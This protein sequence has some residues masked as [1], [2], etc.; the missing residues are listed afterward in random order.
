MSDD[1]TKPPGP[2]LTSGPSLVTEPKTAT[3]SFSAG[4][5]PGRNA[6]GMRSAPGQDKNPFAQAFRSPW[7][8]PSGEQG[9]QQ[10]PTASFAPSITLPTGGGALRSIGE[11]FSPNPFTGTGSMSV[12]VA[13]SPGRA[14]FGPSLALNY[15]SG[16][17][18][19]PFGLG[20]QLGVP[21]ISR[22]TE[23]GVPQYNDGHPDPKQRDTFVLAGAEDLVAALDPMTGGIW[24]EERGGYRIH[25]FRPRVESSFTKIERWTELST[26]EIHWRTISASNVTSYFGKTSDARI[27]DPQ[28]SSRVFSWLLEEV[29]DDRGQ[30]MVYEYKRDDLQGVDVNAPFERTRLEG[31][32]LA[33]QRYLSRIKYGNATPNVASDWLFE[34]V[35]DYG[36]FGTWQVTG[37][38]DQLEISTTP[39]REWPQREDVFST[40]RA[41]FEL[42]TRRL[43]R[44]V[45]MFHHIAELSEEP[46][47]VAS[48]D[49][50]HDEDP[51]MTRVVGIR[52]RSYRLDELT[53]YFEYAELP[54]LDLE[55]SDSG[56]DATIHELGDPTTLANLPGGIDGQRARLVDLDGEGVPGIVLEQPEAGTFFYKPGLGDGRFGPMMA[57]RARPTLLGSSGAQLMDIDGDGQKE[58]VTFA[59]P[60]PGFF[61]RLCGHDD[62]RWGNFRSFAAVPNIDWQDPNLQLIDLVGDGFPDLLLPHANGFAWYRSRGAEGF[63]APRVVMHPGDDRSRPVLLFSDRQS[64]VQFAD[65]TG[66][67]L[68]DLVRIRNGEIAYWPNLGHGRFGP[69]VRMGDVPAFAAPDLFSPDRLR[70][71]DVDGSGTTD[72]LYLDDRGATL[73]HNRAGNRLSGGVSLNTFPGVRSVD[74]CSVVD[75]KGDGTGCLVW[76]SSLPSGRGAMIRYLALTGGQ[77]PHLLIGSRN[78]MGAETKIRY[79]P[80][81]MFY[82]RDKAAG[83]PWATRLPFPVHVV[84]RVESVDH[85]T[86]QRYV[87]TTSYH[88]GF[89]DGIEREF[90]GFGRVETWDTESFDEFGS[91][92]ALFEV[93]LFESVEADLHQPPVHTKSWF[94]TGAYF[95]CESLAEQFAKEYWQAD[96]DAFTLPPSVM[97]AGLTGAESREAARALAGTPLR[98]EV[99]ALDGSADEGRPYS[100][101]DSNAEVVR[102]QA[103]GPNPFG[104]YRVQGRESLAHYYDR[105]TDLSGDYDPRVSHELTLE[106][107]DH[108]A[109]LRTA[110]I[111]YPRRT[112][113][114][115]AKDKLYITLSESDVVHLDATDDVLR[116]A[117][118]IESRG[119]EL[120]GLTAPGSGAFAWQTILDACDEADPIDFEG[121][122]TGPGTEE[123]RLLSRSRIRYLEDDLT[124]PLA[125]GSVQSKALVY[126]SDT[127]AMTEAQRQAVYGLLTGAPTNTELQNEGGYVLDDSAW[128]IRTGH[129]T[130]DASKFYQVTS[131]DDPFGETYSVTYDSH[132]LLITAT[133]D[134]LSQTS[135]AAFDYRVLAP[136]E[137]TDPNGNR[138]QVE[139]DVLGFVV[140]SA[141]L[142]KVGDSD[143]DTLSDP[144]STF[145]Y[146]LFEWSTNGKPNW[147]KSRVRETHRDVG[148]RWLESYSYFG[149]GGGVVMTKVQARPGLA[150]ERDVNGELVFVDDV[151][152]Y[153]DTSPDVRWVGNGRVVKDNKGNVIKAYE[154]YYSSTHAYEDE[155]ELVEQGVTPLMHYDPL[156][157]LIRTDLPNGTFSKVEFTP[158]EQ[159]SYDP[160]D[161][162][163]DSDWYAA[164]YSYGGADVGLLA[165]KRAALLAADHHGTPSVVH[166]DTLGRPFLSVA[167]NIDLNDDAEYF[168]TESVLDIQG[169]VLEVVDARDNTA[170][171]RTYGMLGQSLVVSSVD[172]GDRHTLLNALGQPMR[173]WDSRSQ[174]FSYSYDTLRRPVDR[175]VSVSGGSE[176]LLGRIVYGDLLSSPEDTNH[177]GRVYRVY[178]GAGVATTVEF[179]FKGNPLE[180]QRQLVTSKTTQPD[181]SALLGQSTIAAMATAATSLL[182]SETFSASS[183]RDAVNRVLT[184]ISPDDSEV[185]YTYDEGG[186]LQAVEVKHRGSPTAETVVGDITYNARG[187]RESVV[188]G[189]TSSPTTTTSY[190]YDPQTYRLASLSTVRGSDDA[191]LQGLHYHYDPVGNITD[192]RDTAQQTVYFNNS[193]VEAANSYTYD[194]TYRLIEATGREHSTQGT[195]QRTDVQITIGA[196]PMT[197]DPSAMRR[198][199]QN[200][201]YDEVGNI[202]KMQHIPASGSGWTRYYEYDADGNRLEKTSAPGDP[203]LGPYTHAYTYDAHGNM[204]AMPHLSS[205]VWNHDDE[206]R[207]VTVGTETV[208]FQY[209]GGMRSRKYVE[210]SG[211][212]TEERIYLGPFEIYRKRISGTL[213]LERES[214]HIS[215]DTGRICIIET[216]TVDGGSAVGSPTGIWRYQLSNHLG[217]AVTEVDGSG[218]VIS[219]EEYHPY[220]T[221]S[222]RAVN[223]SIDV[224]SK[225]YR[226]TGMERDEETGLEYHSARYYAPW[227]G[228]WTAGDPIGLGDGVNRFAYCR[229]NPASLSDPNGRSPAVQQSLAE[230]RQAYGSASPDKRSAIGEEIAIYESMLA[231][232]EGEYASA[233]R[234]VGT[235]P[236]P[237]D[238]ELAP[239][240]LAVPNAHPESLVVDHAAARSAWQQKWSDENLVAQMNEGRGMAMAFMG[241][242]LASAVVLATGTEAYLAY[243]A[244]MVGGGAGWSGLGARMS[245]AGFEAGAHVGQAV[246][247]YASADVFTLSAVALGESYVVADAVAHGLPVDLV[248]PGSPSRSLK[249][250]RPQNFRS[251]G[252]APVSP[253]EP[254]QVVWGYGENPSHATIFEG[255]GSELPGTF[256]VPEGTWIRLPPRGGLDRGGSWAADCGVRKHSRG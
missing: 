253:P 75:L 227:L 74:W 62:D 125:H 250:A 99:Y 198:Y 135:S 160:N 195:T 16:Q 229:G 143:G 163:T 203:A 186:T 28:D 179:D 218:A 177:V 149:G 129:P 234:L 9:E 23:R 19:G 256:T 95:A 70:L 4:N 138:T 182:D 81:T 209:A 57:L 52:Q 122:V 51:A 41:G 10:D 7:G 61:D 152:Q 71:A 189:S 50:I 93:E 242:Y 78:N 239:F 67:G 22:K 196:Q 185:I 233:V 164:R 140:K 18:N 30:I 131:A 174:R 200:F 87:Q 130:Y 77:K 244:A 207:E 206:L 20:W 31:A 251:E 252:G 126:D 248:M 249:P 47:L 105:Y 247:T 154:P 29:R 8:G 141:V 151:L 100:V 147:A 161:T 58:L 204:T 134:P 120:H 192:I 112:T 3:P 108:G 213:D 69:I 127:M 153:E 211:A 132:A 32:T 84:Q 241:I 17:G 80:S 109:V 46:Y 221:S 124:D 219:Y 36:E 55:Y 178:D 118:P 231:E 110:S 183:Q 65:M 190:T 237:D 175:T 167:H 156:G 26:G 115:N 235:T 220:G 114:S 222:Y 63:E 180:E 217:S 173:S 254:G 38:G 210:K 1:P 12:P 139:F 236:Y 137:L 243:E 119:Y 117:V 6:S 98:S 170:E 172:A 102:K 121:T 184:A 162:V 144:T 159:T 111:V 33:G 66:D 238:P 53:G 2:Q 146:D 194:A 187:Q 42:R 123:K 35:L 223:A 245:Y 39:A 214:L 107:D 104:V 60:T 169:H 14:G 76:S 94:H 45:L 176:K 40:F 226:Y 72:L 216:K 191:N 201:T 92:E 246:G 188:Y 49:L 205:M 157:R 59:A 34:V 15:G 215:D 197:S 212:T 21:A 255:H 73:Y 27:S 54:T 208:Y 148:T 230:A 158:W 202:L 13:C 199:T 240:S 64:S 89:Y 113:S 68:V 48:T 145:A 133:S 88:H 11:K 97:P 25:R 90:R 116:L 165:E 91:G 86:R 5:A 79:A 56:V 168:E 24:V 37:S 106:V 83:T 181:W 96:A 103:H 142:G 82:L 224:S 155:A 43:C 150:P 85:V 136:W 128:W 101:S 171:S 44:R 193:V 166:L 228:R 232:P 225:R